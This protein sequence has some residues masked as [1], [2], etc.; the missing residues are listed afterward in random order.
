ML[1][2]RGDELELIHARVRDRRVVVIVGEA[3]VG[4]TTLLRA[5]VSGRKSVFEGGGLSTLSWMPYLAFERALGRRLPDADPAWVAGEVERA[6][7]EGVLIIDDAQWTDGPT[8]DAL[9][10]L[11]PRV[12]L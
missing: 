11:A 10:F 6:V 2:G 7:G 9:A 12:A 4:K 5:A 8:R 1:V 3:G